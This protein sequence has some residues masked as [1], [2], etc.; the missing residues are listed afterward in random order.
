MEV[1]RC[2]MAAARIAKYNRKFLTAVK[3]GDRGRAY[4]GNSFNT[5]RAVPAV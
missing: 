1:L 4:I 5:L 2:A 3:A